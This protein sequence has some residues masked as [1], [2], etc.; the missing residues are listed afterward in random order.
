MTH[1]R[2]RWGA[3]APADGVAGV[4]RPLL[5][6]RTAHTAET[7]QMKCSIKRSPEF[8]LHQ[9]SSCL[10]FYAGTLSLTLLTVAV[11]VLKFDENVRGINCR[12][13]NGAGNIIRIDE[14]STAESPVVTRLQEAT[15]YEFLTSCI[16]ST[17]TYPCNP[18]GAVACTHICSKGRPQ[19]QNRLRCKPWRSIFLVLPKITF[20][21]ITVIYAGVL[22]DGLRRR[23][24]TCSDVCWVG[25]Q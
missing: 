5:S 23:R 9:P 18:H 16:C 11:V 7:D 14:N 2:A 4:R 15:H 13:K 21:S 24:R 3:E 8:C 12:V 6:M 17:G 10:N 19:S 25:K 1:A 22:R 20:T